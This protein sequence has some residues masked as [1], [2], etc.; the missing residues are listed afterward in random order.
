MDNLTDAQRKALGDLIAD[1]CQAGVD[2]FGSPEAF[3]E[4]LDAYNGVISFK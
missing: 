1:F 4:A 2:R 3:A